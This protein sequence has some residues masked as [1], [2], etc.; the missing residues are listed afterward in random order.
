MQ[1]SQTDWNLQESPLV[2][3]GPDRQVSDLGPLQNPT[4]AEFSSYRT[5][6]VDSPFTQTH[7]SYAQP[8]EVR[9]PYQ[10]PNSR[11]SKMQRS[12]DTVAEIRSLLPR[13]RK[14][15][16]SSTTQKL[17][18]EVS[19]DNRE[20][21]RPPR[22][23]SQGHAKKTAS[24]RNRLQDPSVNDVKDQ[25]GELVK[26]DLQADANL[27]TRKD[28][29]KLASPRPT[30]SLHSKSKEAQPTAN[31]SRAR[32]KKRAKTPTS[33]AKRK[34]ARGLPR[35]APRKPSIK[36]SSPSEKVPS[37]ITRSKARSALVTS[38]ED[39]GA[40]LSAE[41]TS[42][43]TSLPIEQT[44]TDASTGSVAETST[45]QTRKATREG[46]SEAVTSNAAPALS[47]AEKKD[48]ETSKRR[49]T[50]E[51]VAQKDSGSANRRK[52]AR[53]CKVNATQ[54]HAQKRPKVIACELCHIRRLKCDLQKPCSSCRTV[55]VNC[56]ISNAVLMPVREMLFAA[57]GTQRI[58]SDNTV[59]RALL[60][61]K[62]TNPNSPTAQVNRHL[63]VRLDLVPVMFCVKPRL[64]FNKLLNVL[65]VRAPPRRTLL[66]R[67]WTSQS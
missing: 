13:P 19:V 60:I 61:S 28:A 54:E 11:L 34:V 65:R 51:P 21:T 1:R 4:A 64:K 55:S 48:Q 49:R 12:R 6:S 44:P 35:R 47:E 45:R 36:A 38:A 29:N 41:Q 14:L 53:A 43:A 26:I 56:E 31:Q 33:R 16:F 39:D 67:S 52:R 37:R 18:D 24:S 20:E 22:R 3:H 2:R 40:S 23:K 8:V 32:V 57:L 10:Q 46:L 25:S 15:P 63:K 7:A 59:Q 66:L 58:V 17:A 50:T 27:E 30:V 9:S 42:E 62:R 5:M